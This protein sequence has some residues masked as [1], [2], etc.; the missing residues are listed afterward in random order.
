MSKASHRKLNRAIN[1]RS[2]L[3]FQVK[4]DAA[5]K[6]SRKQRSCRI[7]S[8][9]SGTLTDWNVLPEIKKGVI[10]IT[11]GNDH[12][13]SLELVTLPVSNIQICSLTT[14]SSTLLITTTSAI[15]E[16]PSCFLG[17]FLW[18]VQIPS[19][20]VL[21]VTQICSSR[22][23]NF[24]T[25]GNESESKN[26]FLELKVLWRYSVCCYNE[27]TR[28]TKITLTGCGSTAYVSNCEAILRK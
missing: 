10:S 27:R 14:L 17:I 5:R 15:I 20:H 22:T 21:S 24:G 12:E 6:E 19:F 4:L 7:S 13:S 9:D 3:N 11:K 25:Y 26:K 28:I 18:K 2:A 8:K 23:T 1:R 16:D